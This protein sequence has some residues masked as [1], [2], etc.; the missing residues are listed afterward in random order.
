MSETITYMEDYLD[1]F[2]QVKDI[3]YSIEW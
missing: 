2:H 3:F 1:R